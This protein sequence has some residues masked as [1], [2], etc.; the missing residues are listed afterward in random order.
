MNKPEISVVIPVYNTGKILNETIASVLN[1]SFTDF[2]IV[3]ID[4]G[5]PDADTLQILKEQSDPRIRVIRQQNGGVAMARNRGVVESYGKFI[6]FLDHDDLFAPDKLEIFK[7]TMDESPDAAAVYSTIMPFGEFARAASN[8]PRPEQTDLAALLKHNLIY[9]MSCIMV[10]KEFLQKHQIS[11]DPE[12]VPCDDWDFHLQCALHG[13]ILRLDAPLTRYRL[14]GTNQS[15]DQIKMNLAGIRTIR[16]YRLQLPALSWISGF[17][18][19]V[20]RKATAHALSRHHY[21]IAFQYLNKRNFSQT[22]V[23]LFKGFFY[24]PF[25]TILPCFIWKKLTGKSH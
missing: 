2:E 4:D 5:S 9:S 25:S 22:A 6:A 8:L 20:L 12:C 1:Q 7:K 16:K 19:R 11:F 18:I 15:S 13:K 10:R 17:S 14:H 23:N 24:N 21:S 3:I